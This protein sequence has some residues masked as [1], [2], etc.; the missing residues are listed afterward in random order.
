MPDA[1]TVSRC[2][3]C[4]RLE[5]LAPRR[6]RGCGGNRF[7]PVVAAGGGNL[8]SWTV[9]RRPPVRFKERGPYAVALVEL[10]E[11]VC[12]TGRLDRF[13]PGPELGTRLSVVRVEDGVPVF[14]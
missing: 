11:G 6:C 5:P 2:A 4:G 9:T 10:D 14:G 8:V 3:G 1:L 7:E 13:E 12:V